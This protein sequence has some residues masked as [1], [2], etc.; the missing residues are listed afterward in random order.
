MK[1]E[2]ITIGDELLLGQVIDTNSS[3]LGQE[4]NKLGIHVH[5]KSA[6]SD[7]R[8]AI[9]NALSQAS[10][11]SNI[12]IITGGLG[13]TKDDITKHTLCEYFNTNLIV[14]E[15]VLAWVTDIFVKRNL[16]MIDSN[17]L[18][19]M[20]PQNCEVLWNRSGTAPG[21]WFNENN[22][23]Y[24]SMPGVPFEMKTIFEEEVIPLLKRTFS[25]PS[26]VHRTLQTCSIG[27]S[28]LAKKIEDIEES[29]P[30]H[31]KLAYLPS[32]GAVRLRFSAYGKNEHELNNE[33]NPIIK[34]IYDR[35]GSYIY[36]EGDASLQEVIGKILIEKSKTIATAESCTGGYLSHLITS[37]SGS[38]NYYLGSVIAYHN[39]IKTEQLNVPDSLLK[40]HGAVSE[41]CVIKMAEEIRLKTGSHFALSTSGIAGPTGGS[42]AKPVGTVWIGFSSETKSFGRVFNMGD[43]RER[44]I[45]RTSL[46][47]MDI[48][49]KELLSQD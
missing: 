7:S 15:K 33:L 43:N 29:L 39:K 1:A 30:N 23:V 47:A 6:V 10:T 41:A 24:V 40:E 9:L 27:E 17:K 19:A 21:M 3:W 22:V 8:E 38:S 5:H 28:F 12:V 45:L 4:L 32:V 20:L 36:G 18:Q 34:N 42:E 37:V 46:M 25:F 14:N 49:R 35:I 13:P 48:L 26:I 31:I 2:I 44:T 16:P 11:S